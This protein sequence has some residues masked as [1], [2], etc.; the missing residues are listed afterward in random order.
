VGAWRGG[1]LLLAAAC[2]CIAVDS[3]PR[4]RARRGRG[5]DGAEGLA[6]GCCVLAVAVDVAL[7]HSCC[8]ELLLRIWV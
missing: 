1:G 6:A 3:R 8:W 7:L 4:V 5:L 2:C